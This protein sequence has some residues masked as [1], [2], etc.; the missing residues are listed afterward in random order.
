MQRGL[1][2]FIANNDVVC[3]VTNLQPV[4]KRDKAEKRMTKLSKSAASTAAAKT[5]WDPKSAATSNDPKDVDKPV[6][7][8][9]RILTHDKTFDNVFDLINT[10]VEQKIYGHQG[11]KHCNQIMGYE[12]FTSS[13]VCSGCYWSFYIHC[14][15]VGHYL[16]LGQMILTSLLSSEHGR[17]CGNPGNIVHEE[18]RLRAREFVHENGYKRGRTLNNFRNWVESSYS[19]HISIETA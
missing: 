11:V 4:D 18:F 14:Q 9:K 13:T 15:E 16:S 3:D 1:A 12:Y 6:D 10:Y 7:T 5:R 17:Y 8:L 2:S 19:V